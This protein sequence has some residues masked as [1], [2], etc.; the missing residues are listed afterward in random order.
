MS[1]KPMMDRLRVGRKKGKGP[2]NSTS[3]G[4]KQ[5]PVAKQPAKRPKRRGY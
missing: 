1:F 3:P 4:R 5:Q 2:K